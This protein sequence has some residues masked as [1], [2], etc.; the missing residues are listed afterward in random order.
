MQ[1]FI[2]SLH[3]ALKPL[4]F[5]KKET[6]FPKLK[7]DFISSLTYKKPVW[8]CFLYKYRSSSYRSPAA[9][10]EPITNKRKYLNIRLHST[11]EN[12]A[13]TYESEPVIA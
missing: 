11:N 7:T 6:H 4:G 10:N 3:T 5:K 8:R 1:D 2:I 13:Y 12:R 9:Y